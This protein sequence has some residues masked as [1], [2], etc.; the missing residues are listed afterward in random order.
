MSK[1]LLYCKRKGV[2]FDRQS[3][4]NRDTKNALIRCM[5]LINAGKQ[6]QADNLFKR[7]LT[8][9]WNW[10]KAQGNPFEV[11]DDPHNFEVKINSRNC[12]CDVFIEKEELMYSVIVQISLKVI[13]SIDRDELQEWMCKT[14]SY[15]CIEIDGGWDIIDCVD[16]LFVVQEVISRKKRIKV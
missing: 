9:R 10:R 16:E 14:F 13:P 3:I 8:L 4:K 2:M 15:D 5:A 6:T 7:Q 1:A 12:A 11:C